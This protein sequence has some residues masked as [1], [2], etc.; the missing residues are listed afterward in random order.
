MADDAPVRLARRRVGCSNRLI[1]VFLDDIEEPGGVQVSDFIVLAPRQTAGN[2]VTGAAVLPVLGGTFGLLRIYRHPV[3]DYVWEIPR[4]FVDPGEQARVSALRE[5]SEETGLQCDP[6][7]VVD[8]GT[9]LPEPG[10]VAGRTHLFAA[11]DCRRTGPFEANEMGHR[12]LRFFSDDE[13]AAL[14]SQGAVED[15]ST[16]VAL[17]RYRL[18]RARTP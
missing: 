15:A 12:E 1:E 4:G 13:I 11:T 18:S 7:D 8:L 16:L 17:Y 2:L 5:L 9:V 3:R 14:M 10:I 6:R